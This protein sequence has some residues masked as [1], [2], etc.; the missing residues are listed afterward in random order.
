MTARR[1]I[2]GEVLKLRNGLLIHRHYKAHLAGS[3]QFALT[4]PNQ[5]LQNHEHGSH[6]AEQ[7]Q[8]DPAGGGGYG[9]PSKRS[10]ERVLADIL[11]GKISRESSA[12]FYGVDPDAAVG[13]E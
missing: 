3:S 7:R 6:S 12:E 5:C 11:D 4:P 10:R 8:A 13:S 2:S 9:P 1:M